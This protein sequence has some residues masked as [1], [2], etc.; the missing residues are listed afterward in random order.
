M[1]LIE[2]LAFAVIVGAAL[3]LLAFG[4]ASLVVPVQAERFLFGFASSQQVHILEL[5]LRFVVGAALI[6]Y[7]PRMV[8]P[9]A[10]NLFGW[11]LLVTTACLLLVPWRWHRRF[12]QYVAPRVA[13]HI[14][15]IGWASLVMSGL[16]FWAV[17][18]TSIRQL[19]QADG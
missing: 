2:T 19:V 13:R 9:D 16:I 7:A 18:W 3:Y 12:A 6:L 4:A 14:T 15:S 10:F 17:A 1:S 8:F 11:V 5:F